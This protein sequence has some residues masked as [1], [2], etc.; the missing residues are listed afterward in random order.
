[1]QT[2]RDEHG[3]TTTVNIHSDYFGT[4]LEHFQKPLEFMVETGIYREPQSI[5]GGV[6][7]V[8]ITKIARRLCG[9]MRRPFIRLSERYD[10]WIRDEQYK[11]T[12]NPDPKWEGAL[13]VFPVQKRV[14]PLV[15]PLL[16][17][18]KEYTGG[19]IDPID[20]VIRTSHRSRWGFVFKDRAFFDEYLETVQ[21]DPDMRKVFA[22]KK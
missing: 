8:T 7:V 4:V 16:M 2:K 12:R 9:E 3:I 1:M 10:H 21:N 19:A 17:V 11:W 6:P 5:E 13:I 20:P 14:M 22:G 18:S 15:T